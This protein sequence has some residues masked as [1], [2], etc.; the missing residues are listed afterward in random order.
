ML[1][2]ANSDPTIW[3]A[4]IKTDLPRQHFFNLLG[5]GGS[6]S[7]Q[8]WFFKVAILISEKSCHKLSVMIY[9]GH[10]T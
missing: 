8:I 10:I 4:E 9:E 6:D 2:V 5:V 3:T 1:F 7:V